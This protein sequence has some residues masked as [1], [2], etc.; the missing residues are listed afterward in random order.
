MSLLTLDQ[1]TLFYWNLSNEYSKSK[2]SG[3]KAVEIWTVSVPQ[4]VEPPSSK[5]T[6]STP[7]LTRSNGSRAITALRPPTSVASRTSSALTNGIKI[8][9]ED[10]DGVMEKGAVSDR[11]ETRGEEYQAKK[12]SPVKKGLRLNSQVTII[13]K[14]ER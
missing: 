5:R 7:S 2:L 10:D 4:G 14:V 11:D 3:P 6:D 9:G 12:K 1:T 13:P 8:T